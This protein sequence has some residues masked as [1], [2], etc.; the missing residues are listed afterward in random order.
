MAVQNYD[1]FENIETPSL[2]P[3]TVTNLAHNHNEIYKNTCFE[4][5]GSWTI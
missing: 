2:G 1:G 4:V 3:S 5:P